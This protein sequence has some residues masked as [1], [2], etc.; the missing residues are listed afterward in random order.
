VKIFE[1]ISGFRDGTP[2]YVSWPNLVKIGLCEVAERSRGLPNKK[3]RIQPP[4]WLKWAD[5]AQNS[6]NVVTSWHVHVY[7]IWSG[8]AAFCR[9]YS[10]KIDFFGPKSEY[11]IGFQP[12]IKTYPTENKR[13]K[14]CFIET[15]THILILSS[16]LQYSPIILVFW[17]PNIIAKFP[18]GE[19]NIGGVAIFDQ[20][21]AICVK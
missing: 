6:L 2:K 18:Y 10:G 17:V 19:L 15:A 8:S 14:Y 11:N 20:Y 13:K 5:R 3:T 1:T 9:T 7:R 21:L 4:F 12:T 16:A